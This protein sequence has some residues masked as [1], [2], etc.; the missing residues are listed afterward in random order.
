MR[1]I[2]F[3]NLEEA[4]ECYGR[5]NLIPIDSIR[6]ILFYTRHGC[7]PKFV[8]E[9]ELKPGKITAWFLK[10]E[11]SHIYRKWCESAPEKN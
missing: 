8:F 1:A 5:E 7:Q 2:N 4:I 9:N 11:T 3:E 6:Q 10:A